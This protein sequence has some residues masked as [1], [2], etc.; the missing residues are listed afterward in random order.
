MWRKFFLLKL[1]IPGNI[2]ILNEYTNESTFNFFNTLMQQDKP[3]FFARIGGSDY[4]V[5]KDFY[6]NKSL[7]SN[8]FWLSKARYMVS[9]FNGY[10]DF[11][12]NSDSFLKYINTM[13][14]SYKDCDAASFGGITLIE[15]LKSRISD[16]L[17][18]DTM[19]NK[20][21]LHYSFFESVEPFFKSFKTWGEGKKILIISP[22]S[23]SLLHQKENISKIHKNYR[24]PNFVL[25][26]YNS[27]VTYNNIDDNNQ[28]L[29]ISSK[30][31]NQT[32]I[33][34]SK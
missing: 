2:N 19:A 16:N 3:L 28:T 9:N 32:C 29:N 24:F 15:E 30:N 26:V 7:F 1:Q 25:L 13:T 22:L 10:Y 4:E 31:W 14:N 18:I 34:M 12:K 17:V 33:E 8:P 5:V 23:K 11:D 21:L 20:S 6:L 27:P